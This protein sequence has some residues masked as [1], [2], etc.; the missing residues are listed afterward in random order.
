MLS[1]FL[2]SPDPDL[3][4]GVLIGHTD[5]VW[6][7]VVHSSTGLVLSAAADGTCRLWDHHQTSPQVMEFRAEESECVAVVCAIL[8]QDVGE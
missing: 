3:H 8:K 2:P 4:Q 5:A 6:E 7:L 1:S